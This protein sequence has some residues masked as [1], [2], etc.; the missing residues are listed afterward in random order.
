[1]TQKLS[2]FDIEI[3]T[4]IIVDAQQGKLVAHEQ[5]FRV[6]SKPVFNLSYRLCG[7][8]ELAE[9]VLQN[10]FLRLFNRISSYRC[11]APFGFWLRKVAINECLM[12]LRKKRQLPEVVSLDV[13]EDYTK[14]HQLSAQSLEAEDV[15]HQVVVQAT[16]EKVLAEL[17]DQIRIVLWLKEIEG[18]SHQEIA[19]IMGK[20][21][22]FSKSLVSRAFKRLRGCFAVNEPVQVEGK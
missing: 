3:E 4:T 5:I 9:D 1:M 12:V 7:N 14:V 21:E 22:S 2:P 19:E 10:C 18:F 13:A 8:K 20:T 17:P 16:L 6:F 15:S 11:Q